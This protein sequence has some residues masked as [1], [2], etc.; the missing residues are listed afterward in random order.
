M[1]TKSPGYY[2]ALSKQ[3]RVV[4]FDTYPKPGDKAKES[5]QYLIVGPDGETYTEITL[6]KGEVFPPSG[7]GKGFRYKMSDKTKHK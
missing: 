4:L 5:G 6:S 7:L 2:E 3:L 1:N